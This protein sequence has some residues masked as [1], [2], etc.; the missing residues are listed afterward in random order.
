VSLEINHHKNIQELN[1]DFRN[2][3]AYSELL[4]AR[5]AYFKVSASERRLP[6]FG[7]HL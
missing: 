5:S 1:P 3:G 2:S 7:D 4:R 6:E